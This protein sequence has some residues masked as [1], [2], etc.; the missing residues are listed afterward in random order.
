MVA[1]LMVLLP[2]NKPSFVPA[3][4]RFNAGKDGG[5]VH[6]DNPVKDLSALS[7]VDQEAAPLH[8]PQVLGSHVARYAARL[9]KFPNGVTIAK[10]HLHNP[11]P[12]GM[13]KRPQTLCRLLQGVQRR[14][15]GQFFWVEFS[16]HSIGSRHSI[17]S[18]TID[19]SI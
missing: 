16:G 2:K 3:K 1:T 19:M 14:Q 7:L 17:I 11:Q 8:E 18:Q 9:G 6:F 5:Q 12:M 13:G 4:T 10:Q 15:G